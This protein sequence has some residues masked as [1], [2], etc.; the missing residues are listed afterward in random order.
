M[1]AFDLDKLLEEDQLNEQNMRSSFRFAHKFFTDI[2]RG[3]DGVNYQLPDGRKVWQVGIRSK[4]AYSI[5]LLFSE[6]H[7]PEG[8]QLFIYNSDRTQI[9]GSFTH[10]NNSENNMLPTQPVQ[11]DEIIVEY[12]E[13]GN[14]SFEG[15]LKITEVNHD[16]K[17]I[18]LKVGEPNVDSNTTYPC[19]TDAVCSGIE[20]KEIIRSTV[21]LIING[22]TGCSGTLVNNTKNNQEPYLLTAMHCINSSEPVP[23]NMHFY[24]ERSGT[25][26]T[27][28]NYQRSVCGSS[29]RGI[30]SQ[31]VAGAKPLAVIEKK[32]VA[33][34]RLNESIPDYYNPYFA[35]WNIEENGGPAPH[36]NFHF[37]QKRLKKFGVFDGELSIGS[38]ATA[39]FDP[40]SHWKVSKWTSGA[41][42]GGSSGSP[43]FDASGLLIGSLTG[44]DSQC[45]G[46]SPNNLPDY[47]SILY[48]AWNYG[49][50]DSI[51]LRVWL[52]PGATGITKLPGL[53]PFKSN[54]M[55]RIS[56][57]D[58]NTQPADQLANTQLTSPNTGS[59]FGHNSLAETNEFAEAFNLPERAEIIGAYILTPL[60]TNFS[61]TASPV[62]INVYSGQ[63]Q[64]ETLIG[65]QVFNPVYTGY[66]TTTKDFDYNQPVTMNTG[67]GTENFVVFP[68]NIKIK[69]NFYISYKIEYPSSFNFSVYNT[70]FNSTSHKN[71]AWLRKITGE[72]IAADQYTKQPL[73]TSLAIEPLVVY[74]GGMGID[75]I[76]EK[77]TDIIRYSRADNSLYIDAVPGESGKVI[78][79]SVTGQ[80]LQEVA[81]TG[82]STFNIHSPGKGSVGIVKVISSQRNQA[83]KIIF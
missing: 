64:P 43:L 55:I 27:F 5:N 81:F 2:E 29:M 69:G 20:N 16:Y 67:K 70:N 61:G 56:N 42:Q 49:A 79:Y 9:I 19:M 72:W 40:M 57:V 4:N 1:P 46:S 52:D 25:I 73:N 51:N 8:G 68:D 83:S 62:R 45:N 31:S 6:F 38:Y 11:G 44:G 75:N 66:R 14:S 33:L 13:P 28:F 22:N 3:K 54:P 76:S 37:P 7:I 82:S 47:F 63:N 17:D 23:R 50:Q 65:S 80:K 78:V 32:D 39:Y 53:D 30:E 10:E 34:L 24:E 18:F 48:K 41:T 71:T 58:Y 36:T 77:K 15:R 60:I 59:L 21:L 74:S 35:G 26:V 12:S